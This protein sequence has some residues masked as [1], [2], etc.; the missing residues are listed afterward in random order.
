[1][2]VHNSKVCD[3]L[4]CDEVPEANNWPFVIKERR[5]KGTVLKFAS[6]F[7][8]NKELELIKFARRVKLCFVH[9]L[10]DALKPISRSNYCA[11]LERKAKI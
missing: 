10:R 1:M 6:A 2:I 3:I 11:Y 8:G 5:G 4:L 9:L 7:S